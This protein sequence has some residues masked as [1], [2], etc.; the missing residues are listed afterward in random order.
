M[1]I[2]HVVECFAAGT[3]HFI[4][5]LTQYTSCEHIVIHGER[6]DEIS[7][8]AVKAKF[9]QGVT[10]IQ[11]KNAQR[12]IRPG[13]DLMALREL[14]TILKNLKDIDVIHLH[15]SKAGF[16]GRAA[17]FILGLKNVIYTPNGASFARAD[18]STKNK[19]LYILL[20]KVADKLA[21]EVVCCSPSEAQSYEK[22][23]IN[24]SFINNGTSIPTLDPE[25]PQPCKGAPFRIVTCGRITE[26]KN[27][28]LFNQIASFFKQQQD[29]TFTWIGEGA[30]EQRA[31]LNSGNI[32]VTGWLPKREVEDI[33]TRA[34]LYL[35]TSLWEGLP[36][37][38]L[39]ALS[40]GKCLLL[41]DCV[42][43]RDLVKNGYNGYSFLTADEAISRIQWLMRNQESVKQMG[44]N[45]R[46][47]SEKEFDIELVS[48]QYQ[49][50]YASFAKRRKD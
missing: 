22:I 11:W 6:R 34:D 39:E 33:L 26:Q 3:A 12:E 31:V 8:E 21:G 7:A 48:K 44:R 25:T 27:P 14:T 49:N 30:M 19:S 43:N 23:G 13:K 29:I 41:S 35:S 10:F 1:K 9:P 2:V 36:F 50:L 24:T 47:W 46:E 40:L 28:K 42:G 4:N 17:C 32:K 45:S 15:S 20:E 37:S 5:L 18:V 16:L 38:V